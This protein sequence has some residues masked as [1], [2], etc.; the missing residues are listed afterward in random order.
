MA[1]RWPFLFLFFFFPPFFL[2][3][4]FL[5]VQIM[6]VLHVC[7]LLTWECFIKF[8]L[9]KRRGVSASRFYLKKQN[10][11]YKNKFRDIP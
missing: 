2:L 10:K 3:F 11:T 6:Y 9:M 4:F 8:L 5:K 7:T 1:F